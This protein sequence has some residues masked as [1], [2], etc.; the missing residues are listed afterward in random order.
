[1]LELT[2]ATKQDISYTITAAAS[3]FVIFSLKLPTLPTISTLIPP[4]DFAMHQSASLAQSK[5]FIL[6][7]SVPF[8]TIQAKGPTPSFKATG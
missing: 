7:E 4:T 3:F 1:M 6:T 8:H 2:I 5:H